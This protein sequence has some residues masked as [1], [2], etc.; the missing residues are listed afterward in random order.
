MSVDSSCPYFS[1][2]AQEVSKKPAAQRS[3]ALIGVEQKVFDSHL[4]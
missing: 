4:P 1:T 2:V 3:V